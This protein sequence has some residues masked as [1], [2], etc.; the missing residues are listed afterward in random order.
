MANSTNT[1]L[2]VTRQEH[3]HLQFSRHALIES[4]CV[5]FG[6]VFGTVIIATCVGAA[7]AAALAALSTLSPTFIA[8]YSILASLLAAKLAYDNCC[9]C[10]RLENATITD[11]STHSSPRHARQIPSAQYRLSPNTAV[12]ESSSSSGRLAR[13]LFPAEHDNAGHEQTLLGNSESSSSSSL[14]SSSSSHPSSSLTGLALNTN[15]VAGDNK[16][17]PDLSPSPRPRSPLQSPTNTPISKTGGSL[18]TASTS[19]RPTTVPPLDSLFTPPAATPLVT[20]ASLLS[21]S[22]NLLSSPS[23]QRSSAQQ[24][25]NTTSSSSAEIQSPDLLSPSRIP[26]I[27]LTTYPGVS[28]PTSSVSSSARLE[29]NTPTTPDTVPKDLSQ[30]VT[31]ALSPHATPVKTIPAGSMSGRNSMRRHSAPNA[32]SPGLEMQEISG[33]IVVKRTTITEEIVQRPV[34]SGA[35]PIGQGL[36]SSTSPTAQTLS[37]PTRGQR[38]LFGLLPP[39]KQS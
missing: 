27:P 32:G 10:P 9:C 34:T 14:S 36:T 8:F 7:T 33:G 1:T 21:D 30:A 12:E 39:K 15:T 13:E 19:P 2:P 3:G 23:P 5:R 35:S 16:L 6:R 4:R 31:D 20:V 17:F 22:T 29:I 38:R 11:V 37:S 18:A 24:Q 28:P 25:Q 26:G